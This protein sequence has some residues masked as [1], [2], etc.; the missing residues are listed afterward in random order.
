MLFILA[1]TISLCT[2]LRHADR[3]DRIRRMIWAFDLSVVKEGVHKFDCGH[4]LQEHRRHRSWRAELKR[5]IMAAL[6]AGGR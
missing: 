6:L 1:V 5:E 2:S 3:H 4:S